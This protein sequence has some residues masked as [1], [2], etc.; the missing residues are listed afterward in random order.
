MKAG[1]QVVDVAP[2]L[3]R[4]LSTRDA[5]AYLGM[6]MMRLRRLIAKNKIR[7]LRD[8]R[9]GIYERWCDEFIEQRSTQA[10][11]AGAVAQEPART[12]TTT[13]I[14]DLLPA[15]RLFPRAS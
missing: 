8:G 1:V 3:G 7:V 13:G 4:L 9:L 6:S 14:D 2:K 11:R 12:A 10:T 5:A 15:K